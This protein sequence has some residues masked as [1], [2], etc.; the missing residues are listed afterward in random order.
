MKLVCIFLL[1]IVA[2]TTTITCD[3]VD[4]PPF[5][6]CEYIFPAV[7]CYAA[8][9]DGGCTELRGNMALGECINNNTQCRCRWR[10]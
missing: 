7:D 8:V 9:C 5:K 10:C 6:V 1:L 3:D 2:T 4:A